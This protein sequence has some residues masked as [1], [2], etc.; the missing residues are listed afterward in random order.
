MASTSF[1]VYGFPGMFGMQLSPG[2]VMRV[3]AV[4]GCTKKPEDVRSSSFFMSE[5][6]SDTYSFDKESMPVV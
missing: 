1:T 5:L 3:I 4:N 6:T 2:A